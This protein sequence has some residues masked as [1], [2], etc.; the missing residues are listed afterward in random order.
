MS[1]AKP[2]KSSDEPKKNAQILTNMMSNKIKKVSD[3]PDLADINQEK[4][5]ELKEI[6]VG[7][8]NS[9]KKENTRLKYDNTK[10]ISDWFIHEVKKE[11]RDKAMAN[12]EEAN[13]SHV[14]DALSIG[15]WITAKKSKNEI[16]EDQDNNGDTQ[17]RD[18]EGLQENVAYDFLNNCKK[19]NSL[20]Q[21]LKFIFQICYLIL[22]IKS[23]KY[24]ERFDLN[25]TFYK[26]ILTPYNMYTGKYVPLETT[27]SIGVAI[28]YCNATLSSL[29]EPAP[30]GNVMFP[31][32]TSAIQQKE[33]IRV[34]TSEKD[35]YWS[36]FNFRTSYNI[37]EGFETKLEIQNSSGNV[38]FTNNVTLGSKYNNIIGYKTK[39]N[40]FNDW[41]GNIDY[42]I[43][44]ISKISLTLDVGF[45]NTNFNT[46]VKYSIFFD[47]HTA[48]GLTA[49]MNFKAAG[50]HK[51]KLS[52]NNVEKWFF[53][54]SGF[55]AIILLFEIVFEINTF[56]NLN[57]NDRNTP[58]LALFLFMNICLMIYAIHNIL[59]MSQYSLE[60]N[61][62]DVTFD[63]FE[64]QIGNKLD[65]EYW[66]SCMTIIVGLKCLFYINE[67]LYFKLAPIIWTITW[68]TKR[69]LPYLFM[70]FLI[71]YVFNCYYCMVVNR[72]IQWF[73]SKVLSILVFWQ[74]VNFNTFKIDNQLENKLD[75]TYFEIF[76][77]G[78]QTTLFK[79]F[80]IL[81][82]AAIAESYNEICQLFQD[83]LQNYNTY[84][85]EHNKK[86][87][88][89]LKNFLLCKVEK[90]DKNIKF[91][92]FDIVKNNFIKWQSGVK[93]NQ[94]SK[95]K[96]KES[97]EKIKRK[98]EIEKTMREHNYM[99]QLL[100]PRKKHVKNIFYWSL[101]IMAVYFFTIRLQ[102]PSQANQQIKSLKLSIEWNTE[103]KYFVDRNNLKSLYSRIWYQES[104]VKSTNYFN[105]YEFMNWFPYTKYSGKIVFQK[106]Q[107]KSD[108]YEN[109]KNLRYT[110]S[111]KRNSLKNLAMDDY[112]PYYMRDD[113]YGN[114]TNITYPV[115]NGD[116]LL[117]LT[118][119]NSYQYFQPCY[120]PILKLPVNNT[121]YTAFCQFQT[122]VNFY[123]VYTQ[124]V[125]N[126]DEAGL[127]TLL[128]D[129]RILDINQANLSWI[130][131][132]VNLEQNVIAMVRSETVQQVGGACVHNL[133]VE[134]TKI[135]N[136]R[137]KG[138]HIWS[139][140]IY[141]TICLIICVISYWHLYRKFLKK[142][143]QTHRNLREEFQEKEKLDT[144]IKGS[145]MSKIN[146]IIKFI[147]SFI[148][149]FFIYATSSGFFNLCRIAWIFDQMMYLETMF[150]LLASIDAIADHS[151]IKEK[152]PLQ[153]DMEDTALRQHY[154]ILSEA[155][156]NISAIEGK[157]GGLM[158]GILGFQIIPSLFHSEPYKQFKIALFLSGD[159]L[160]NFFIIVVIIIFMYCLLIYIWLSSFYEGLHTIIGLF[161]GAMLHHDI[162]MDYQM[163]DQPYSCIILFIIA[164]FIIYL[165]IPA[166]IFA[167]MNHNLGT[168]QKLQKQIHGYFL[169]ASESMMI[170]KRPDVEKMKYKKE[171]IGQHTMN[172]IFQDLDNKS[173]GFI[174]VKR[175]IAK[176]RKKF[177]KVKGIVYQKTE[178]RFI[179][180][181][182]YLEDSLYN[183][184]LDSFTLNYNSENQDETKK[185][186][187]NDR[188]KFIENGVCN[189]LYDVEHGLFHLPHSNDQLAYIIKNLNTEVRLPYHLPY[190]DK[191]TD[192]PELIIK[193]TEKLKPEALKTMSLT[194]EV[195]KKKVSGLWKKLKKNLPE[196]KQKMLSFAQDNN[197][198]KQ[199]K[200]NAL[201][202]ENKISKND[203]DFLLETIFARSKIYKHLVMLNYDRKSSEMKD[204]QTENLNRQQNIFQTKDFITNK[205][206]EIKIQNKTT[207]PTLDLSKYIQKLFTEYQTKLSQNNPKEKEDPETDKEKEDPETDK[208]KQENLNEKPEVQRENYQIEINTIIEPAKLSGAKIDI[209][210]K[211]KSFKSKKTFIPLPETFFNVVSKKKEEKV[212][213]DYN[214]EKRVLKG[215]IQFYFEQ[216]KIKID[217]SVNEVGNIS[218]SI[219]NILFDNK[220]IASSL[221]LNTNSDY[222]L[223]SKYFYQSDC[224]IYEDFLEKVKGSY[225]HL[226][227]KIHKNAN[228]KNKSYIH[229]FGA[230][231]GKY[232]KN[233]KFTNDDCIK[234]STQSPRKA[235]K[236]YLSMSKMMVNREKK[237]KSKDFAAVKENPIQIFLK[238]ILK[239][240]I[241]DNSDNGV[242]CSE[243]KSNLISKSLTE[244][245]EIQN[246]KKKFNAK[247][248]LNEARNISKNRKYHKN[249]SLF[250]A[251]FCLNHKDHHTSNNHADV[252]EYKRKIMLLDFCI[253]CMCKCTP[254]GAQEN[255]MSS[256]D[257]IKWQELWCT[258]ADY[259]NLPLKINEYTIIN[260]QKNNQCFMILIKRYWIS[261]PCEVRKCLWS[262]DEFS[263]KHVLRALIFFSLSFTNCRIDNSTY[264]QTLG[265]SYK[266]KRIPDKD[267]KFNESPL[268]SMI[269]GDTI[270]SE[271][272]EVEGL[273][274]KRF[275]LKDIS[276]EKSDKYDK[277]DQVIGEI[278]EE[279]PNDQLSYMSDQ[280]NQFGNTMVTKNNSVY[281]GPND[282]S[283]PSG[284]AKRAITEYHEDDKKITLKKKIDSE[285][286]ELHPSELKNTMYKDRVFG[287]EFGN[288]INV[289]FFK[290]E[291]KDFQEEIITMQY[292]SVHAC[293]IKRL[294]N[295]SE[296]LFKITQEH[297]NDNLGRLNALEN[298]ID[299]FCRKLYVNN[300]KGLYILK[301]S[302]I[303]NLKKVEIKKGSL[304]KVASEFMKKKYNAGLATE[305]SSQNYNKDNEIISEKTAKNY[306]IREEGDNSQKEENSEDQNDKNLE[307]QNPENLSNK[308]A[309]E[310]SMEYKKENFFDSLEAE[311]IVSLK[312]SI[313]DSDSKSKSDDGNEI[314]KNVPKEI[315]MNT[316]ENSYNIK[317][318]NVL[319]QQWKKPNKHGYKFNLLFI[320]SS[321]RSI[322]L[323]WKYNDQGKIK[324]F[325]ATIESGEDTGYIRTTVSDV[326]CVE[327]DGLMIAVYRPNYEIQ[328]ED[329]I[330]LEINESL[331]TEICNE[332]K[333][334]LSHDFADTYNSG[335]KYGIFERNQLWI[336][337][338]FAEKLLYL[339]LMDTKSEFNDVYIDYIC[340]ECAEM[341]SQN[342]TTSFDKLLN[343]SLNLQKNTLSRHAM[344]ID[345]TLF[346]QFDPMANK[347]FLREEKVIKKITSLTE[348]I[349]SC[350]KIYQSLKEHYNIDE[351]EYDFQDE[352]QKVW[353]L[354]KKKLK[355]K[356][357]LNKKS[358]PIA[359]EIRTYVKENH[360]C[361]Q[362]NNERITL[363]HLCTYHKSEFNT[364]LLDT[365]LRADIN[366]L[367]ANYKEIV[368]LKHYMKSLIFEKETQRTGRIGKK[369]VGSSMF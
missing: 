278:N 22:T 136:L 83:A 232:T 240:D 358:I 252:N 55:I 280:A 335:M 57:T 39:A 245:L 84:L 92:I 230:V 272:I 9:V 58:R 327:C 292:D 6:E 293:E 348:S 157:F 206:L 34:L 7:L 48:S 250:F 236:H 169:K 17:I 318:S 336:S 244:L 298:S 243:T 242:D 180:R 32:L 332:P 208:E 220:E 123:S 314:N 46:V 5:Q 313:D 40:K 195:T 222:S 158:I 364:V 129:D 247:N 273:N 260:N 227:D 155:M 145:L 69:Y 323:K 177:N 210:G 360:K 47:Y 296:L 261:M 277:E 162:T 197:V 184:E 60:T 249:H 262:S 340:K 21:C 170:K 182:N 124:K 89:K 156:K 116:S 109:Q 331:I 315:E 59:I 23:L 20:L 54:M 82:V 237:K 65:I 150:A 1:Y 96:L 276:F 13:L 171:A 337:M 268:K 28:Q 303:D 120:M 365:V 31:Y 19:K 35:G 265:K 322:V 213:M 53:L 142:Y 122:I 343:I 166:Y 350:Q 160:R 188:H 62:T 190:E 233:C 107:I 289:E 202:I 218:Q 235:N 42:Y 287:K 108:V 326:F 338:S 74:A 203:R 175:S 259:Q 357:L 204:R 229:Y 147:K 344:N 105:T 139:I 308:Q 132:F 98:A 140:L 70:I 330:I 29:I 291:T 352:K 110:I 144:D 191:K 363:N 85:E 38:L 151:H 285:E 61:L 200:L 217:E 148:Y 189:N 112:S 216:V 33:T 356:I 104:A 198:L 347:Y 81:Q 282:S 179:E 130:M 43:H 228:M 15:L 196:L 201:Y 14:R 288:N 77:F 266:K 119:T 226:S 297:D 88:V 135:S 270:K 37:L 16:N 137:E 186:L 238:Q 133:I 113:F 3:Q 299:M 223:R 264:Y 141:A 121:L 267:V 56:L 367:K 295:Q 71:Y 106:V 44:N 102:L 294:Q 353:E 275:T 324:M 161:M 334:A 103:G 10:A 325:Q 362:H 269:S 307:E 66:L 254:N 349:K 12:G 290:L 101:I 178:S 25:K 345:L 168:V 99:V 185:N 215:I 284:K 72:N 4:I 159:L 165:V 2:R 263:K 361:L 234:E 127:Q 26:N 286:S 301:R 192:E 274:Q 11:S 248:T 41:Q 319:Q 114:I 342:I 205:E 146:A 100:K 125:Y 87:I 86:N 366:A 49:K 73:V 199:K 251:E 128:F 91:S 30:M 306:G 279:N 50:I 24:A 211:K 317:P 214:T 138:V 309:Q 95:D 310:D 90:N 328:L 79:F 126:G 359:M 153:L 94:N 93:E 36:P 154:V 351:F 341:K 187:E 369:D 316:L 329:Q 333:D 283:K 257:A 143:W 221:K 231:L 241:V 225:K 255:C 354:H 80:L 212:K 27:D 258:D 302:E 183:G 320:N 172:L 115:I 355:R 305:K 117:S 152:S 131:Q 346:Y 164:T 368:E 207:N 173:S 52:V 300:K 256:I 339:Q 167:I 149:Q 181:E 45:L 75:F 174:W 224:N 253:Y 209:D 312:V 64:K 51:S 219:M 311:K 304:L 134:V 194:K 271:A 246:K 63:S 118:K 163:T 68:R 321:K 76:L 67:I 193:K 281:K 78:I 239:K 18:V 176:L 8:I 97:L 111:S